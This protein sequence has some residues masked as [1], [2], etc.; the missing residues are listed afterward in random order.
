[1]PCP[2]ARERPGE[3]EPKLQVVGVL[4]AG[5]D[6]WL[7][8]HRP[9]PEQARLVGDLRRCRTAALGGHLYVCPDCGH[10]VP[11]YNSCRNRHCPACQALAQ[12]RWIQ[13]RSEVLLPVGHHH[14]VFT[15]P[16]QL[17]ALA[18]AYPKPFY[19][20]LF[21]CV[22]DTLVTL[23]R[24]TFDAL[25]GITA[26]LH[27]WT[28]ELQYH[29]HV[30]C[31]VTAGGLAADGRAWI[32]RQDFL[33]P[34][35]RM[36]AFFRARLLAGLDDLRDRGQLRIPQAEWLEIQRRLPPKDKWVVYT[37]APFG[38]SAHVLAYLGRYTHRV[39]ISDSRLVHVDADYISFVTRD[40]KVLQL[41]I[42]SFIGRFM[43]HVLPR[44]FHKIRHFGLYA[45][46]RAR[47]AL[48]DARALIGD[49]DQDDPIA[50]GPSEPP[51]ADT[52]WADLLLRLTGRDPL[53]CPACGRARLLRARSL[54][55]SMSTPTSPAACP[56]S[57]PRSP[58]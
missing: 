22:R 11:L 16:D 29:P 19:D 58:T 33:L 6:A 17:R 41:P 53:L 49:G 34:V 57:A 37:E 30:H 18:K 13:A 25:P 1:M 26:V 50:P 32:E 8:S 27:T 44:G 42:P 14:I 10:K 54:S 15:V 46:G 40:E 12:A 38:R 35:A 28:R 21:A 2:L 52:A 9:V 4:R 24:A 23:A 36:K 5:L 31:I 56:P 7:A 43:L 47:T 20:L 51:P 48:Q 55:P 39:A 3:A 45:P